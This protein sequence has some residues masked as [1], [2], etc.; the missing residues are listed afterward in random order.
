M[1]ATGETTFHMPNY[2]GDALIGA[3]AGPRGTY[4]LGGQIGSDEVSLDPRNY[5]PSLGGGGQSFIITRRPSRPIFSS[6]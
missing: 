1:A 6:P 5:P 4:V 3:G 2:Q